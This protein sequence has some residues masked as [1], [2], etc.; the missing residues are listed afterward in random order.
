MLAFAGTDPNQTVNVMEATDGFSFGSPTVLPNFMS[1]HGVGLA[2]SAT[3]GRLYLAFAG[4][5][6]YKSINIAY[7]TD[8]VN[9]S[10]PSIYVGWASPSS[11]G[12]VMVANPGE[13]LGA[14]GVAWTGDGSY[15]YPAYVLGLDC[16]AQNS[17]ITGPVSQPFMYDSSGGKHTHWGVPAGPPAP[18][19]PTFAPSRTSRG[20][21]TFTRK[22]MPQPCRPPNLA[23]T[24]AR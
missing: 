2:Y 24:G 3:C 13:N 10:T 19:E 23:A 14:V 21:T 18:P 11:S 1:S 12:P 9:W 17:T 7:S 20:S 4:Q 22:R 8:A 15:N 5:D 6:Q 16:N